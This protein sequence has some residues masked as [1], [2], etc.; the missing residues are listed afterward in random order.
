VAV[1]GDGTVG[2]IA[3]HLLR[4]FSPVGLVVVGQRPEQAGLAA[5]L[6]ATAFGLVGS[7]D[8]EGRFDLVVEAAETPAAVESA[9][10]LARRGGRVLPL[11]LG[12]NGMNAGFPIDDVVNSDLVIGASFATP[13]AHGRK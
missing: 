3:A 4:L 7:A 11:G 5:A 10:W 13:R 6:G 9:F 8:L 1:V 12:G 2:L